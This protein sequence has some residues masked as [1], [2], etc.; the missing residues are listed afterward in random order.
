VDYL[1]RRKLARL[2][3]TTA[4]D[5]LPGYYVDRMIVIDGKWNELTAKEQERRA[6][7]RTKK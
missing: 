3:F 1:E 5:S 4:V 2:G 6:K 7:M